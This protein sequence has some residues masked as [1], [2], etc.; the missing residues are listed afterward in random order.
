MVAAQRF[1]PKD[2]MEP[3]SDLGDVE[4]AYTGLPDI[5]LAHIGMVSHHLQAG[6]ILVSC[7]SIPSCAKGFWWRLR[8]IRMLVP[9]NSSELP[10]KATTMP[11]LLI[12]LNICLMRS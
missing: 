10:W 3:I 12:T 5:K 8:A 11:Q 9:A 1:V 6:I 7:E 2:G 4:G